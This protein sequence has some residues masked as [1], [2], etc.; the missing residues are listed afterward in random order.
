MSILL[1][2]RCSRRPTR[3]LPL[4]LAVLLAGATG[5]EDKKDDDPPPRPPAPV[6]ISIN[7]TQGPIGGGN[8]VTITG[9][10]FQ[11]GA[12]VNRVAF[13]VTDA[14]ALSVQSD[15]QLV[16]TV[17][18][19]V[20][21]AVQVVINSDANVTSVAEP[22]AYLY[23]TAPAPAP[24]IA[25]V[26]PAFG[27]VGGGQAVTI[28]GTG[29]QPG[30]VVTFAGINA[31]TVQVN[32]SSRLTATTPAGSLGAV[33]VRVTNPD[34]QLDTLTNGF[35]YISP[36]VQTSAFT[37]DTSA[38]ID[39]R[40]RWFINFN[41][42]SYYK[43][44]QNLGLQS[45]GMPGDTTAPPNPLPAVDQLVLDWARAYT[46]QT[47][48]VAY[49]RNADGTKVSGTSINVTFVGI[50][51]ASGTQGC[52][53]AASDWG[54]VCVGGCDPA[55]NGGPHPSPSQ[56]ACTLGALGAM[57]Y[58]NF[59][60][61]SCNQVAECGC[62]TTYHQSGCAT[63]GTGIFSAIIGNS[64]GASLPGGRITAAD[65]QYLDGTTVVGTRYNQ[66]H[67][68]LQQWGHRCAFIAAHEV[69]HA[70]GLS[71]TATTGTCQFSVSGGLCG[72][73][74]AH[75]DCCTGNLMNSAA[76]FLAPVTLSATTAQFSGMPGSAVQ[77][78]GCFTGGPSSWAQLQAF[79][80]TSP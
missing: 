40:R 70:M 43:D 80:G 22:G 52:V 31:T 75:N 57:N 10:N 6:F 51:P 44:L 35:T 15:T 79:C 72:G 64:W 1:L 18:P 62:D 74:G 34:A 29:Y 45:W 39:C 68:F 17:P 4:A 14:T 24:T 69:G 38:G 3:L 7:P 67:N 11:L 71:A 30:A 54:K 77:S 13:G 48:N 21:G 61:G 56:A 2:K 8:Q 26:S 28:T 59:G 73:T 12:G 41:Q 27:V 63:S 37:F 23:F 58:D 76:V 20:A 50:V 5:C 25:A 32:G 66:I 46:L 55:G 16:C 53:N 78:G 36:D 42:P 65:L 9:A 19:G 47:L 49:G 60:G 33:D